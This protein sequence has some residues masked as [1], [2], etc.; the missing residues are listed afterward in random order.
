VSAL[1]IHTNCDSLISF[2]TAAPENRA[3]VSNLSCL[4]SIPNMG[5]TFARSMAFV[6]V[7]NIESDVTFLILFK[8]IFS[9]SNMANA[10]TL[11]PECDLNQPTQIVAESCMVFG[12][13][14]LTSIKRVAKC[15][16]V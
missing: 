7:G 16:N 10:C 14:K 12:V 6:E 15:T 5:T 13:G 1:K 4:V 11:L 2:G 3:H 9:E 8:H